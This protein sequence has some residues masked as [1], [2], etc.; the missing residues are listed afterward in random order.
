MADNT[1][2]LYFEIHVRPM[3][4]EIDREH[5]LD[6]FDLWDA[7]SVRDHLPQLK[8]WITAAPTVNDPRAVMPPTD[9]GGPWPAEWIATFLRWI[10][11][12]ALSLPLA[13][14]TYSVMDLGTN[15]QWAITAD[16]SLS[17][18]GSA[19]WLEAAPGRKIPPTFYLYEKPPLQGAAGSGDP[20]SIPEVFVRNG[21]A[22]I[23]V[24]D[25]D[26]THNVPLV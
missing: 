16:G 7:Q 13:T 6:R 19:V 25:K 10:D 12:G 1:V 11:E 18:P 21:A 26:G 20:F 22:S 23:E 8:R 3:F 5:M 17:Q 24:I 9:S 2:P 14:A 15:D 4:R